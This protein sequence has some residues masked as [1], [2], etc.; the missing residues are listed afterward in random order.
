[1]ISFEQPP[2]IVHHWAPFNESQPG[3]ASSPGYRR[4][5]ERQRAALDSPYGLEVRHRVKVLR[6]LWVG[7]GRCGVESFIRG[8]WEALA[9]ALW[10]DAM[11]TLVHLTAHARN[12]RRRA[13]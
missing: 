12:G 7:D 8:P 6:L 11:M 4:A 3:G 9:L 2:W 10:R 5:V 13:E 1:M